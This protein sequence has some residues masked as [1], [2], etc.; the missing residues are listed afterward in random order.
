MTEKLK[1]CPFCGEKDEVW[2]I[3]RMDG[4]YW[5]QCPD[6]GGSGSREATEEEAVIAW[7]RRAYEVK[8]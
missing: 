2:V 7:N 3:Q 6:C 4:P 1:P 8:E 5:V